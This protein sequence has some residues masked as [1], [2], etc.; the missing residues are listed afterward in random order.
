MNFD[1]PIE[2]RNTHS[3]KWDMMEALYGVPAED[4]ISMWV[5]DTDFQAPE[6]VLKRLH[7]LADHGVFGYSNI[8]GDYRK[9]IQWWMENRHGW[10]IDT[11]MIFTTTGLCNAVALCLDTYTQPGDGVVLFTPVYHAFA[12]VTRTAGREVVECPL[13][14]N[15]GRYEMDF[16]AYDAQMT[17]NAKVVILCSPHN[18]GGRVWTQEELQGVADFCARHDLLLISDEIHHDLVYPGAKHIAMPLAAPEVLPRLVMLT[19]PSKTFNVAGLHTGNVIIPDAALR[20]K[21]AARMSAL[22]LSPNT[23]GQ[24]VAEACYSPEGAAW[25]DAQVAYLDENRKLFDEVVN[26][27]PGLKSMTLESTFLA[28]VDFSGTGMEPSEFTARVEKQ[29]QIAANHGDT[30]GSGGESFLRFNLGTQRARIQDA[31]ERLREAFSDLQ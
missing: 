7:E 16:D 22:A 24:F 9:A 4:G 27:I 14:D 21:F 18:P 17:G 6:H 20:A 23:V 12:R 26:A 1:T 10:Q 3:T 11:D 8:D 5:A 25:V 13:V 29:A 2:R 31:A 19:A 30:F 15:D 28:W